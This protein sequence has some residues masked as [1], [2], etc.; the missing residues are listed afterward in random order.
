VI[1]QSPKLDA[2]SEPLKLRS[3]YRTLYQGACFPPLFHSGRRAVASG[4]SFV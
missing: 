3:G 1:A 4:S 2:S